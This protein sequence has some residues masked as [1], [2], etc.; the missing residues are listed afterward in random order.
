M[1]GIR[2]RARRLSAELGVATK[3]AGL[4]TA[5][6]KPRGVQH[7]IDHHSSESTVLSKYEGDVAAAGAAN[8]ASAAVASVAG[9]GLIEGGGGGG[10]GGKEAYASFLEA[11]RL[12][13][14]EREGASGEGGEKPRHRASSAA[15]AVS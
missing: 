4:R 5:N 9:G 12:R 13:R 8:A 2:V 14:E 1:H 6:L 10:G 15:C 11:E 7:R 3:V